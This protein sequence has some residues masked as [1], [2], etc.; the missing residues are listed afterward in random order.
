MK[1]A[2][3]SNDGDRWRAAAEEEFNSLKEHETWELCELP[4]GRK[5]VGSK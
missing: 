3:E 2:L 4:E 1:Q 5:V